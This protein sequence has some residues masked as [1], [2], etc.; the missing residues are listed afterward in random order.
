MIKRHTPAKN[1]FSI[2]FDC[3]DVIFS[4][5]KSHLSPSVL[6]PLIHTFIKTD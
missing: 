3:D 6:L 1:Y 4:D 5:H 2:I